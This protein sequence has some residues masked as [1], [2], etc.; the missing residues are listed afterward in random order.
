MHLCIAETYK[1]MSIHCSISPTE[2]LYKNLLYISFLRQQIKA[3]NVQCILILLYYIN[4]LCN[5]VCKH[6][7][8]ANKSYFQSL[9]PGGNTTQQTTTEDTTTTEHRSL[10]TTQMT[11]ESHTTTTSPFI[12][13]TTT[14]NQQLTT[15]PATTESYATPTSLFIND[16]STESGS[17]TTELHDNITITITNSQ[18]FDGINFTQQLPTKEFGV[19]Q[20]RE[21]V[22]WALMATFALLFIGLLTV[23][24]TAVC[25]YKWIH[26]IHSD[27]P[28]NM[29]AYEMEGNP[30]YE[31]VKVEQTTRD[32]GENIYEGIV[33]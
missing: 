13:Y 4:L 20:T 3:Q 17:P 22:A 14:E 23:N 16:T 33:L 24:I 8:H 5:Y 9:T 11:T 26:T 25:I 29:T 6:S 18:Q 10:T 31:A 32:Q 7:L 2:S 27:D 28:N 12:E 1:T 21:I 19:M 30:C 15:P